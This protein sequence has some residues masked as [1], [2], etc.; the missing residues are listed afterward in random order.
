MIICAKCGVELDDEMKSCPLCGKSTESGNNVQN[1]LVTTPSEVISY[2]KKV[3]KKYFWELSGIVAF[4]GIIACTSVDILNEK[5]LHWS[6]FADISILTAWL[7][8]TLII[9]LKRKPFLM[10]SFAGLNILILLFVIDFLASGSWWFFSLGVPLTFATIILI[11]LI[12]L[13]YSKAGFV[14]FNLLAASLFLCSIYCIVS[15]T[16]ID[17][18]KYGSIDIKWS[19]IV[20]VSILPVVLILFFLHYR[21]KRGEKLDSF[22]HV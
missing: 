10:L 21:M 7:L 18:Y 5:G 17:H 15:E 13:L 19:L 1:H 20:T 16:L 8:L 12:N 3:R 22:F 11:I 9:Q 14:G 6:L 2:H 4:S